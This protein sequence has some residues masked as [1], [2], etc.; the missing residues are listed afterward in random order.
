M[1]PDREST[2]PTAMGA[3]RVGTGT[4]SAP[5]GT[6]TEGRGGAGHGATTARPSGGGGYIGSEAQAPLTERQPSGELHSE[7]GPD[8][9]RGGVTGGETHEGR[10]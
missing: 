8:A 7:N 5:H 9:Q 4:R 10:G 1:T 3:G 2:G 6:H